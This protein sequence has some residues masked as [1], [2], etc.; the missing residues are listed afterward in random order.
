MSSVQRSRNVVVLGVGFV[1]LWAVSAFLHGHAPTTVES[2]GSAAAHH[3]AHDDGSN[4]DGAHTVSVHEHDA[5]VLTMVAVPEPGA[6]PL[7]VGVI[8]VVLVASAGVL[9]SVRP[10][11]APPELASAQLH[12]LLLV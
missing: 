7:P 5:R 10:P 11:R 8:V 1:L 12:D 6:N 2:I 4:G 9:T 3:G